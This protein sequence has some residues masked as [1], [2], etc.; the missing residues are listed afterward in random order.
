M[1]E[2]EWERIPEAT[3][4]GGFKVQDEQAVQEQR[5][6]VWDLIK[7]LGQSITQ[8]ISLTRITIPIYIA[9]PRSYLEMV[10]DGWCYGPHFLNK[11]VESN[12]PVERMKYV[13]SFAISGL[14]NTCCA[15]KPLNP[16]LGETFQA[17]FEDGTKIFC[18]QVSHHPPVTNWQVE[19][20]DESYHFYGSG[21]L[22]AAFRGNSIRG[23]QEGIHVVKF[24]DGSSVC[25]KLPEVWVRGIMFGERIIEY[26][27]PITFHDKTNRIYAELRINPE[28]GGWFTWK[29]KPSDYIMGAIFRYE[30]TP[31]NRKQICTIEGSW[32][33][34]VVFDK[35]YYWN[36]K[37][38]LPKAKPIPVDDPLPSDCRFRKDIIQMKAG[39]MTAANNGKHELETK[40]RAEAA[41][42]KQYCEKHKI[43]YVAA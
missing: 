22:S 6:V 14:S 43:P 4:T 9:D 41:L 8:G 31:Q 32:L 26:D 36:W 7:Q 10:A 25:Y 35:K 33:G 16:L 28:P 34:C 1:A 3:P 24:K 39:D 40:Q 42:R 21:E 20:P 23:H 27:G 15:K 2:V 18:E 12:D 17:T 38:N 13:I 29:K 11:A 37:D 30:G 5:G 19:G